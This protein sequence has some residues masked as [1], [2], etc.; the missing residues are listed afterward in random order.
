[1]NRVF[2]NIV[3]NSIKYNKDILVK[4]KI[5]L[6]EIDDFIVIEVSDN[7]KGVLDEEF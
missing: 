3:E 7:G 4:I 1:M 6:Y 2:F 5:L